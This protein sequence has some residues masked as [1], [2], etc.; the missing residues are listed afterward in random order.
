MSRQVCLREI[1]A[2]LRRQLSR[3][4][5][6][7]TKLSTCGPLTHWMHV[8]SPLHG[9][10][11]AALASL[12]RCMQPLVPS[13]QLSS[14]PP[15][16]SCPVSRIAST[17]SKHDMRPARH[18]VP[19]AGSTPRQANFA[20]RKSSRQPEWQVRNSSFASCLHWSAIAKLALK[21]NITTATTVKANDPLAGRELEKLVEDLRRC[22]MPYTCPHG[23]P[24]LIEMN[25]RELEKKFGRTQ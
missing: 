5:S 2:A 12:K 22:A 3:Q 6:R 13:V 18:A 15:A 11:Q 25:F 21:T 17:S 8:G 24:T 4:V 14:V 16:G 23:R 20:D 1:T 7:Q 19:Q 10:P 9:A